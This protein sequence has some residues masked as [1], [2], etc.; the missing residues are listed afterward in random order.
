MLT[1]VDFDELVELS[2]NLVER[3]FSLLLIED[4]GL[5]SSIFLLELL[6][7]QLQ[8]S[9]VSNVCHTGLGISED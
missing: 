4:L 3:L 5:E 9:L 7:F 1:S 2:L 6:V 8:I